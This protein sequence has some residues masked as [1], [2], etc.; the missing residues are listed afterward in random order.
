MKM[1][2]II[3]IVTM[4]SFSIS[5][6]GC[7]VSRVY[8]QAD[9]DQINESQNIVKVVTD[10]S[11]EVRFDSDS[12]ASVKLTDKSVEEQSRNGVIKSIPIDSVKTFHT[13]DFS[14]ALT[15]L[16]SVGFIAVAGLVYIGILRKAASQ[17]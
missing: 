12:T 7:Y 17:D 10:N 9:R 8:Q 5:S 3:T 4:V 6:F 13:K 1:R 2:T 11:V 16:S 15:V 14:I